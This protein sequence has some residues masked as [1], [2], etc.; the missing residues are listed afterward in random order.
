MGP[1]TD[2]LANQMS[3][4]FDSGNDNDNFGD[5]NSGNFGDKNFGGNEPQSQ[6]TPPHTSQ[7]RAP[8]LLDNERVSTTAS[9]TEARF[10]SGDL[11]VPRKTTWSQLN[12]HLPVQRAK[13]RRQPSDAEKATTMARREAQRKTRAAFEDDLETMLQKHVE[14]AQV[15]A[16]KHGKSHDYIKKI[17]NSTSNFRTHRAPSLHNAIIHHKTQKING[18]RHN[19]S[20][21]FGSTQIQQSVPLANG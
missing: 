1:L 11:N 3:N 7:E 16:D 2:D 19:L 12:P 9:D 10:R 21:M 18:G 8:Q 5:G 6:T 20:L 14:E 15:L 17:I 4:N 13:Q